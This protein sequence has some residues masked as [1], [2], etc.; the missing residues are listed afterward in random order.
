MIC[1]H[2]RC[3]SSQGLTSTPGFNL[4]LQHRLR[5]Y[6]G[7]LGKAR[8]VIPTDTRRRLYFSPPP[9]FLVTLELKWFQRRVKCSQN[10]EML[11]YKR[12]LDHGAAAFR[13]SG[14]FC[15]QQH[16]ETFFIL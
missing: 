1:T 4:G 13:V 3:A 7:Y 15:R 8:G 10:M 5:Q 16:N 6:L 11:P 14:Y 12:E 2:T 9:P